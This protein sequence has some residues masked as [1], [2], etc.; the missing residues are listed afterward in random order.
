M[1]GDSDNAVV[2]AASISDP[3]KISNEATQIDS[4][5]SSKSKTCTVIPPL[6]AERSE[7]KKAAVADSK[8]KRAKG[9]ERSREEIDAVADSNSKRAKDAERSREDIDAVSKRAKDAERSREEID[10]AA[11]S[12]SKRAKSGGHGGTAVPVMVA[13]PNQKM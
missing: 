2:E 5:L 8:S 10:T 9:A 6:G 7:E 11:D 13:A 1:M 4:H 12:N 3:F